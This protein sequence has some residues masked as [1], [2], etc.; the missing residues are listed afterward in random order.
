MFLMVILPMLLL[1]MLVQFGSPGSSH[2]F[3]CWNVSVGHIEYNGGQGFNV[4]FGQCESLYFGKFVL[5][6][7]VRDHLAQGLEGVVELVHSL[8]LALVA[9]QS[10]QEPVLTAPRTLASACGDLSALLVSSIPPFLASQTFHQFLFSHCWLFGKCFFVNSLPLF[11]SFGSS[12]HVLLDGLV[13][14]I[15]V[16]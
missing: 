9:L 13:L 5:G 12:L 6:A 16:L 11:L 2:P 15:N 14:I 4:I 1:T 10:P 8:P 3:Y 7:D